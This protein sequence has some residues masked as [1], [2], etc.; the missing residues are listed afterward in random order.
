MFLGGHHI[1]CNQ[2]IIF[3]RSKIR[4]SVNI[5]QRVSIRADVSPRGL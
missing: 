2:M 4:R 1:G 3:A 5:D